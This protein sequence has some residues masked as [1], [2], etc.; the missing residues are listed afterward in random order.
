MSASYPTSVKT[1]V[2][3]NAGDVIQ[4][5]H[6]N[7]LQDEVNAIETGL[8]SGLA[9]SL[10][11]SPDNASDIGAAGTNRP[12]DIFAS[13]AI[14]ADSLT[15]TN[16]TLGRAVF[17]SAAAVSAGLQLSSVG[18]SGKS[19]SILSQ[20]DGSLKIQDDADG[21]PAIIF[22]GE[23]IGLTAAGGTVASGG[24]I[25]Q[26]FTFNSG[27]LT[28]AQITSNQN[29]YSPAGIGSATIV[30]LSSDASR[31]ITGIASGGSGQRQLLVNAG[32]QDIVLVHESASSTA[33]NR[34]ACPG[35]VNFTL[36][37]RDSAWTWYD[38]VDARWR[39]VGV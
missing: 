2:S 26:G 18:G 12:R 15:V 24:L 8:K 17:I 25:N 13:R 27:V 37:T 28:P 5:A 19:W 31:Q 3:R 11:F 34:F 14:N 36:N 33:A 32:A 29:D 35:A 38:N 4:P 22:V 39:V 21:T 1:F 10:L 30:R 20:T 6:I 16:S 9:H 7:D 23:Q